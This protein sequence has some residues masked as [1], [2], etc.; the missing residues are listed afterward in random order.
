[1]DGPELMKA[2]YYKKLQIVN[3]KYQISNPGI[4]DHC[5]PLTFHSRRA[6]FTLLEIMIALA[7]VGTALIAILHTVNYHAQVAYENILTTRMLLLAKE[8]I[9]EMEMSSK[10]DEGLF[11]ETDFSYETRVRDIKDL[12][13]I[14]DEAKDAGIVELRAIV[15]GYGKEV[16]LSELVFKK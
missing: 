5:S 15:R 2:I 10:N 9:S 11:P 6:G 7:I 13:L 14:K 3:F 8:K 16:E 1:M 12:Q 4:S